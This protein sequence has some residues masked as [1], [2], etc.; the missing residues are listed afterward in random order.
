MYKTLYTLK[1]IKLNNYNK[2]NTILFAIACI[3]ILI[4][5]RVFAK[6][7]YNLNSF[8]YLQIQNNDLRILKNLQ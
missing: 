7:F 8:L 1:I 6:K 5:R 2:K 4:L 3:K